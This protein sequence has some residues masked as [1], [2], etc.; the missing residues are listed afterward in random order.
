MTFR[1]SAQW[2]ER[3]D[4]V[5][6][7]QA[8]TIARLNAVPGVESAAFSQLLPAARDIPPN[9]FQVYGRDPREKTFALGRSVSSGYFRTLHIPVLTG[10][11]CGNDPAA[12]VFSSAL[13]TKAF[14]DRYFRSED[15]I[16]HAFVSPGQLSNRTTK[17][18]GIVGDVRESGALSE[19]EPLIYWC[20]YNPYWPD[21][22]FLVRTRSDRQ[23]SMT[24]IREA[25]KEIEPAR[26]VYA[27]QSLK[28]LLAA[29]LSPQR[30]NAILLALFATTALLL[31]AIGLYGV[32]SQLVAARRREIG[33]RMALG[34]RPSR[35]LSAVVAQAA[36][37]TG[38]GIAAGL[39][40]SLV[41]ARF[42]TTLV[43]GVSVR[44]PLTFLL[45][46]IV[47]ALVA[48]ISALVPARR[49]ARVDPMDVLRD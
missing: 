25:L 7:R 38:L 31:A 35:I 45:V 41:L 10:D 2:S 4:A 42:M 34:A 21:Q 23:V 3:F 47:L 1:M 26:A 29:S 32:L 33:V 39:G 12:P 24:A 9:E 36:A 27:E 43:F 14:A 6:Q 16:G 37:L 44:D 20:G 15:P 13:V 40:A 49:A 30:V 18:V 17:I 22:Y 5:V 11:T 28:D 46:P 48:A 19:P 8:R